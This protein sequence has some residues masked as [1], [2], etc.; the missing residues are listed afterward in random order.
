MKNEALQQF[1]RL[2][3]KSSFKTWIKRIV[4]NCCLM[5]LRDRRAKHMHRSMTLTAPRASLH[6]NT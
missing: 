5:Q 3:G 6:P 2:R 4:V 1:H